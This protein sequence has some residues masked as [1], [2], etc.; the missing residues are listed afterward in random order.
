MWTPGTYNPARQLGAVLGDAPAAA[1]CPTRSKWWLVLAAAVGAFAG[2][3][4]TAPKKKPGRR[5]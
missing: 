2:F 3:K 1:S 5:G 4:Y